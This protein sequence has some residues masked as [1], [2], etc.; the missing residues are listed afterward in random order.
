M[1]SRLFC[2]ETALQRLIIDVTSLS[3]FLLNQHELFGLS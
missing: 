1:K 3:S 2:E